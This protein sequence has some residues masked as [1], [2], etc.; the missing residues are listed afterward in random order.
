[1]RVPQS[2]EDLQLDIDVLRCVVIHRFGR[3]P[4]GMAQRETAGRGVRRWGK[5]K[6]IGVD[7]AFASHGDEA[8]E[9]FS[10]PAILT[11]MNGK[12]VS[13]KFMKVG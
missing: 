5:P 7:L 11:N 13:R 12:S 1:M 9:V 6:V 4:A 10:V 3:W 8:K 2:M